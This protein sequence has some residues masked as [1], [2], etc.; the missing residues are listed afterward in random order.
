MP[1]NWGVNQLKAHAILT[2]NSRHMAN[3]IIMSGVLVDGSRHDARKLEEDPKRCFKCQLI[4]AGHM[5]PNCKAEEACSNCTQ[6]ENAEPRKLN[7]DASPARKKE[8]KM[9]T[10]LGTDNAQCLLRR[11]H[12]YATGSQRITIDSSQQNT[13]IGHGYKMKIV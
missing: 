4:G 13:K 1:D 8:D 11:R 3:D 5:A 7:S 2:L 12:T 10:P 6:K 9:T